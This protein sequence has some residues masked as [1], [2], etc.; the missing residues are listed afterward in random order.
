MGVKIFSNR[1]RV[2]RGI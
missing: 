1:V 2:L